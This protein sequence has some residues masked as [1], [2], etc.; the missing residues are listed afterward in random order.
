MK[1]LR[2]KPAILVVGRVVGLRQHLR[3]F[4]ERPLFGK[5][6]RRHPIA[7]AG[8]RARR[9]ARVA[10]RRADRGADDPR[11]SRRTTTVRSTR[12]RAEAGT[13]DWIVF[14]SAN[15][16]DFFMRRLMAG[17]G[18]IRDLKG[19]KLVRD[20]SGDGRTPRHARD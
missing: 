13:Y 20:W 18:D 19:V 17:D 9:S 8:R 4:D 3:W 12:R 15:G 11:R 5:K 10:G 1:N 6:H 14:T 7:R 2:T 16:V